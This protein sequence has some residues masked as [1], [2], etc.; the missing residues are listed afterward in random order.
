MT[1]QPGLQIGPNMF[2]GLQ[3]NPYPIYDM[4]RASGRVHHV[5]PGAWLVTRYDDCLALLRDDRMSSDPTSSELYRVMMPQLMR[6]ASP[7]AAMVPRLLL[8]MDPPDHTR[9]RGLVSAA[10][11]RGAVEQ[12]RPRIAELAEEM[13]AAAREAGGFDLVTDFA[14]PLPVTVIAELL[15]V[16]VADHDRFGAWARDLIALLGQD[17]SAEVADRADAAVLAFNEYFTAL[18]DE[19]KRSPRD[20]LLTHMVETE[21]EGERLATEELLATCILL[22]LAGHETTANLISIGTLALL[23]H[24]DV[25]QRLRGDPSLVPTCVEELLRFDSPVQATA[26]TTM[27]PIEIAGQEIEAGQRVMLLLGCANRDPDTFDRADELV[28]ERRPNPHIGL[29]GGIHFCLGAPLAR[30]EARVVFEALVGLDKLE[31]ACDEVSWR[32]SFAI[33][34]L[35]SLPV[36]L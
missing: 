34:G 19:R 31:L 18:A 13:L 16:P 27:E 24:P 15:G 7:A 22:L 25:L 2:A 1:Q 36:A 23:R 33:R 20:D 28:P 6:E 9:L 4:L 29:G 10:F 21:V 32:A 11:T 12:L 14:Y 5:P 30:L 26:R 3:Q 35:E 8:F 17:S